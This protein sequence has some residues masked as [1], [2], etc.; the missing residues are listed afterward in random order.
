MTESASL[1]VS[2]AA[3]LPVAALESLRTTETLRLVR[4]ALAERDRARGLATG[5]ENALERLV[6]SPDLD[7]P[8]RRAALRLRRDIHN[9]R[10]SQ[11][12]S[13][14]ATL[15][16]PHLD[17]DLRARLADWQEAARAWCELLA[18]AEQT[19]LAETARAGAAMLSRLKDPRIVRGGLA[20]ASPAFTAELLKHPAGTAPSWDSKLA[21][22]ATAYLTRGTVKPSPFGTLTTV[23]LSDWEGRSADEGTKSLA[24]VST[25]RAVA[26]DLL[27]AWVEH[28]DAPPRLGVL[29]NPSTRR[30][31]TRTFA[32][33]PLYGRANG[34]FLR[35]DEIT[36]CGEAAQVLDKLP[37]Y[38]I[39]LA[40]AA[41]VLGVG[42]DEVARW[43]AL[44]LLHP[45]TPWA[46]S[47]GRHF[48]AFAEVVD[49]TPGAFADAVRALADVEAQLD[50]DP[51]AN[52]VVGLDRRA[53][54]ATTA[55]YRALDRRPPDWLPHVGLLHN[56]AGHGQERCLP[57]SAAVRDD[58][59]RAVA[60][61]RPRL[62]RVE[63]YDRMLERFTHWYGT[64]GSADLLTFC[65]RLLT[66]DFS[67]L[68]YLRPGARER[69][70]AVGAAGHGTVGR[71]THTV[72]FQVAA[73]SWNQVERGE[74]LTVVNTLHCGFTGLLSRW[75]AI[76]ALHDRLDSAFTAWFE[77]QHPGC[78]VYQMSAHADWVGFQRPTLRGIPR[79]GWGADLADE[80][81]DAHDLRHFRLVHDTATDTLQ[82]RDHDGLPAAFAYLGAISL[83]QLRGV[84]RVLATLSDPWMLQPP[85]SSP[86][87]HQPR[88]QRGRVVLRR[89]TWHMAAHQLP[90]PVRGQSPARFLTEVESWR[91]QHHLP[92]EVFLTQTTQIR[93]EYRKPQWMGFDHPH[94]L[95]AVLR[96]IEDSVTVDIA[97]ALPASTEHWAPE[98][99]DSPTATE[100]I[101]MVRHD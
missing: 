74:H 90:R 100:F 7:R 6:P 98:G 71:A 44:G 30:L 65:Y 13:A 84:D 26:L 82:V 77:G 94:S 85:D 67:P 60:E 47:Q 64:G 9:L 99:Q 20:L 72:F 16:V 61:T 96:Q 73:R 28:A 46:L 93:S 76:P 89:E 43:V 81:H 48:R 59:H 18:Q 34:V 101:G 80:G 8:E 12:T 15:L 19:A 22:S 21:R 54:S 58:L 2:R 95:W 40:K 11:A 4:E 5:L 53:R 88:L 78:R 69:T 66:T 62:H 83:S 1:I 79:I 14:A 10:L 36:D 49:E 23:G 29:R 75:A 50:G 51:Q 31:G 56:A 25:H 63:L 41:D 37:P 38:P 39:S 3:G 55:A 42:Q 45:V 27:R 87:P 92:D 32:A 33:L 86:S 70:L 68:W 24:A 57:L 17:A 35:E 52:D 91:R 97:E